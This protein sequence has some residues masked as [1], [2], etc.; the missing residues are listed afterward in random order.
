[1]YQATQAP[2]VLVIGNGVSRSHLNIHGL[3][4]V[5]PT[6]GC[7]A[8]A[9]SFYPKILVTAD[10]SMT[11]EIQNLPSPYQGLH[12]FKTKPSP[13]W[14]VKYKGR[15]EKSLDLPGW[16]SGGVALYSACYYFSPREVV[17]IGFDLDWAPTGKVNN[18][19]AGTQHYPD[20]DRKPTGAGNFINQF[21]IVARRFPQI[22]F[23]RMIT[24]DSAI[25]KPL[26]KIPNL[27]HSTYEENVCSI[28][29]QKFSLTPE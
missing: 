17:A 6:C 10:P 14:T 24:D 1:M 20:K 9:R 4:V 13:S 12:I 29:F 18:M 25:N 21:K 11:T 15:P 22:T 28:S 7:N 26:N 19:Y 23:V 27:N 2:T 3:G 8:L 5:Y 16:A